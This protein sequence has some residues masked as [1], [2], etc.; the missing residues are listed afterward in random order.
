M[1]RRRT[2]LLLAL[3]VGWSFG[4]RAWYGVSE[5]LYRTFWDEK[6]T[7]R[8]IK[9]ALVTGDLEPNNGYYSTF[10]YM[11]ATIVLAA[12]EGVHRLTRED[13]QESLVLARAPKAN[14]WGL[15]VTGFRTARLLTALIGA[16]C[17]LPVFFLGRHVFGASIGWLSALALGFMP[18]HIRAGAWVKPDALWSLTVT[19]ALLWA[20]RAV[21]SPTRK[22]FAL[23]GFG[24]ALATS[25]KFPGGV[26]ALALTLGTLL[27]PGTWKKRIEWLVIAGGTALAAFLLL[28]P[29]LGISLTYLNRL[30]GEYAYRAGQR[31][32]T[33]LGSL[34]KVVKNFLPDLLGPA[35][36]LLF[37]A[38]LVWLAWACWRRRRAGG[39]GAAYLVLLSF[40]F[41]YVGAY[42]AKTPLYKANNL[43]P[44]L[45]LVLMLSFWFLRE[46][47]NQ[48]LGSPTVRRLTGTLAFVAIAIMTVGH[49]HRF[50]YSALVPTTEVIAR[51]DQRSVMGPPKVA[52]LLYTEQYPKGDWKYQGWKPLSKMTARAVLDREQLT[53]TPD[54]L[55]DLAD[56][57]VFNLLGRNS[58]EVESL[59]VRFEKNQPARV[60]EFRARPFKVRGPPLL[61]VSHA[62]KLREPRRHL[63]V[64]LRETVARARVLPRVKVGEVVSL[65]VWTGGAR[66]ST[67]RQ[68]HIGEQAVA[69]H[70]SSTTGRGGTMY[71]SDR[72][73]TRPDERRIK[74]PLDGA[75]EIRVD[76]YRWLPREP[77][78]S[79]DQG[80]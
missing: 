80:E 39:R 18:L 51:R 46:A 27:A 26:T 75:R 29:Y 58:S 70:A 52:R 77:S 3:L 42:F 50:V 1:S 43:L 61:S 21:E 79:E 40:P 8:N 25:A 45:P 74:I 78:P 6:A 68:A 30:S 17:V 11:P 14:V 34:T 19:L 7:V 22:R 5:I 53:D 57:V 72:F 37:G 55:L 67:T 65:V 2:A 20:V 23:A 64:R 31:G 71:V 38:G 36:P 28:N 56:G 60:R 66:R 24:V 48:W 49:G 54:E 10:S 76:L 9:Q 63:E 59:R 62:W 16:L 4:L 41:V 13:D 44:I 35:T 32:V 69:L 15:S 33:I 12:M 73:V 47:S